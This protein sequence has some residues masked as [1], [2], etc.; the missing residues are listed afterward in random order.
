[1]DTGDPGESFEELFAA[2]EKAVE[3]LERGDLPL[4]ECIRRYEQGFRALGRCYSLLESA[5]RRIEILGREFAQASGAESSVNT[6][7]RWEPAS[8]VQ[9]LK[10]A[11][12][13]VDREQQDSSRN[14]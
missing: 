2:A 5:Q 4:E 12:E 13:R 14:R 11:L 3:S 6:A 10:E 7:V 1:M 8:A 9:P